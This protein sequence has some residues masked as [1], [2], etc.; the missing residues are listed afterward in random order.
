[1]KYGLLI[2]LFLFFHISLSLNATTAQ[3]Y[4]IKKAN[5]LYVATS[6]AQAIEV[7]EEISKQGYESATLYY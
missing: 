1:M 3:V 2:Q 7:Y 4:D 6:Y 5:D